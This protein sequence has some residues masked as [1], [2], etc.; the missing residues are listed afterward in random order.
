M[1]TLFDDG[2][3]GSPSKLIEDLVTLH[4]HVHDSLKWRADSMR[5]D[6]DSLDSAR[7]GFERWLD[8]LVRQLEWLRDAHGVQEHAE[9]EPDNRGESC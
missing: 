1:A 6:A 7:D 9:L 8:Q 3:W 4:S 2:L 5:K